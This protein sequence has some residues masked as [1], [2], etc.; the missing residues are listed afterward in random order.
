MKKIILI[1]LVP[2]MFYASQTI[3]QVVCPKGE[4]YIV[5]W[6]SNSSYSMPI[7]RCEKIKKRKGK[8]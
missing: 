5:R 4:H 6:D 3:Q 1:F 8:K 2:A 7:Q